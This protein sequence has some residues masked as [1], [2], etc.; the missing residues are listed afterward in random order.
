MFSINHL[1]I[2]VPNFDPCPSVSVSQ[3]DLTI[4]QNA[5]RNTEKKNNFMEI[6][7]EKWKKQVGAFGKTYLEDV[8]W[9]L[10]YNP[11]LNGDITHKLKNHSKEN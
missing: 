3:P 1:I 8:F 9:I 5:W 7:M 4:N 6:A 11:R 2:G 10:L